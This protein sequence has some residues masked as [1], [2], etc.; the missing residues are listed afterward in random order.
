MKIQT[1]YNYEKTWTLT[2]D[3]D[4]LKIIKEEVGDSDPN[5]ILIYIKEATKDDKI[6]SVG[7]CR[8]RKQK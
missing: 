4:L 8:F 6:I 2:S 1:Q 5:G 7:S 3:D